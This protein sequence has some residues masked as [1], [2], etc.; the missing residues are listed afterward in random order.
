MTD[1]HAALAAKAEAARPGPWRVYESMQADTFVLVG[2]KGLLA[3]DVIA[4]PTYE[5]RNAE[6]IAAASPDVVLGLIRDLAD[7]NARI[8]AIQKM[9]RPKRTESPRYAPAEHERLETFTEMR[10]V[11]NALAADAHPEPKVR[12]CGKP[13]AS[14]GCVFER[15]HD[16]P[17]AG[18][19]SIRGQDEQE[20]RQR[21]GT[22][23]EP[24]RG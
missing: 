13:T 3:D 17:C 11:D 16:S 14:G 22:H 7:A 6:Y 2:E 24:T 18:W 8:E 5:R 23:P 12:L 1:A 4:G 19:D 15:G 21:R 9:H 10:E 20:R